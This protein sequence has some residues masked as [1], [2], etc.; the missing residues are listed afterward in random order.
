MWNCKHC[1]EQIEDDFEVC[2]NC[3]YGKDGSRP[4]RAENNESEPRHTDDSSP[5]DGERAFAWIFCFFYLS[6]MAGVLGTLVALG[7]AYFFKGVS[8]GVG[9]LVPLM[10]LGLLPHAAKIVMV[11]LV[12]TRGMSAMKRLGK[13][14]AAIHS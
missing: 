13:V 12:S 3:Q 10:V 11:A 8:S 7:L 1:G 5:S 2:W 9:F 6:V 14:V 4:S